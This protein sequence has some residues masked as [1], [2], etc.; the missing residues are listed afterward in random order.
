M[1][2]KATE[3]NRKPDLVP[4]TRVATPSLSP[5]ST[6]SEV[7]E[8]LGRLRLDLISD[9]MDAAINAIQRVLPELEIHS[10]PTGSKWN[11]TPLPEK[12][13]IE[14]GRLETEA[15]KTVFSLDDHPLHITAYSQSLESVISYEE[16]ES[17]LVSS[18]ENVPYQVEY[19][20]TT[21]GV[22]CTEEQRR[23]LSDES[24]R[25]VIR[26]TKTFGMM[27][28]GQ[29]RLSGNR[30]EKILV[31]A[32]VGHTEFLNDGLPGVAMAIDLVKS[33]APRK[34]RCWTW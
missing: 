7:I 11:S 33:L 5:N 6:S 22:C 27:R 12:W 21:W 23:L 26:A 1:M 9:G 3:E 13:T 25:V 24:Y 31:I 15:G 32:K 19:R 20:S 4:E 10:Y 16:L 34:D 28:V 17:R 18:S 14:E 29:L 2:A 8:A 30:P